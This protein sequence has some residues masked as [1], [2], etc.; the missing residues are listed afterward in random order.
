MKKA[1]KFGRALAVAL[2]IILAMMLSLGLSSCDNDKKKSG[3]T[4]SSNETSSNDISTSTDDTSSSDD[5]TAPDSSTS[6]D[7]STSIDETTSPEVTTGPDEPQPHVHTEV[8]DKAVAPT[9]T[10]A[11]LTEGKHCSVCGAVTVSQTVVKAKG[12]TEVVDKAVSAT[13][14]TNGKTE[15]KHCSVC[16]VVTLEQTSLPLT[17]HTYDNDKD[18]KC[19]TC[20]FVRDVNCKHTQTVT[21]KAVS[22]TCT[23]GGLTE[24]KKCS[25]C[26]EIL[27]PQTTVKALGHA[28]VVDP[29]KAATCT[30][31]GL[32]E[33]KHCSRCN[34]ILVVQTTIKAKGH[35]E[36]T[37]KAVAATCTTAGKTEGKHCSVC[38]TVTVA[39]T[40]VKA[41]GHTEVTDKAVAA[42]CTADGKTE[43]KHCSV[44]NTVTVAQNVV[45]AKGHTE[46]KWVTDKEATNTE[47]GKR[48]QICSVCGT[49]LKE[50]VI[51]AKG[52]A[53]L[54]YEVNSD[55][56]TCTVTGI[57]TCTDKTVV[58]GEHI[59]GYRVTNIG[60]HAFFECE[61]LTSVNIPNSVTSIG[62]CAFSGCGNLTSINIPD[63][64]TSIGG[65]TFSNCGSLTTVN[66]G[67]T[68]EE[69][70]AIEIGAG[71]GKLT[72]IK[73]H[74]PALFYDYFIKC[75]DYYGLGEFASPDQLTG[76]DIFRIADV[77]PYKTITEEYYV[78][79]YD[80]WFTEEIAVYA[81]SDFDKYTLSIFGRTYD[82]SDIVSQVESSSH[83]YIYVLDYDA[84]NNEIHEYLGS[85]AGGGGYDN[86]DCEYDNYVEVEQGKFEIN[87]HY[88]ELIW[89]EDEYEIIETIDTDITG[90]IIVELVDGNYLMR[91]HTVTHP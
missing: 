19:N 43:G 11:G 14:T 39:Q 2:S 15:G 91:S 69:W 21:L 29:A 24:G 50:E 17:N 57:G 28:E 84:E 35:T 82:Y 7:E 86:Y 67:G 40:T 13:C 85:G 90:K 20:G 63:S 16:S 61:K 54:E 62:S 30:A 78:P 45:K 47:N 79:E 56:K 41:K 81:V 32:T 72:N 18:E 44:C 70:E 46:G 34:D 26:N 31:T 42:T 77:S 25:G 48:R 12:H 55:G 59:D 37:D 27:V 76:Y 4:S 73:P 49:T 38:G 9:C 22:P 80:E 52:S 10:A 1:M 66:Y 5:T 89:D 33:G 53:G 60:D 8:I 23:A 65:Y 58:I 87:Y 83:P 75:S 68:S 51:P 3:G 88:V 74:L 36:V 64:V 6:Q 71:N